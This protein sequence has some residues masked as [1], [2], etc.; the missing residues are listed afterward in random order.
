MCPAETAGLEARGRSEHGGLVKIGPFLALLVLAPALGRADTLRVPEDHKSIQAAIEAARAGDTILVAAGSYREHLVLKPG[1]TVRSAGDD[2]PGELGL[3]RAEATVLD[4]ENRAEAG[5]VMAEGSTLDGFTVTR[6]GRFD[7]ESWNKHYETRGEHQEHEHIGGFGKP[8]IGVD[9]VNCS[10]SNNIVHHNGH[11]GIAVRGTEESLITPIVQRNLC[12][13]NMGGGIGI[14]NKAS[15]V[16]A[17]NTCFRNFYAGIGHSGASPL[18]VSNICYDNIRAG[19]GISE[20]ACPA[21]RSNKCYRNRRAGIGIRTGAHTRPL[22]EDNDCYEN[23]MAGIGTEEE[24]EP[25]ILH[26]RC[27]RNELAGIGARKNARPLLVGNDCRHN[28]AAGIGFDTCE[29][30]EATLIRNEV[31]D[32]A[33][34]AVGIH[35]GWTVHLRENELSRQG[36]LPPIVMVFE[37]AQAT[38]ENNTIRGEGVAGVR[39]AGR[40]T[41]EGN[42]FEGIKMR[43]G[44]P[45]NFGVWALEGSWL[46]MHGN[47]FSSWRHGLLADGAVVDASE[48]SVRGFHRTALVVRNAPRPARLTGNRAFAS[49]KDDRVLELKGESGEVRGN[50]LLPAK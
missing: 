23:G 29:K 28:K 40:A 9:G 50:E 3:K 12:Y 1:L 27:H 35:S 11:T 38:L 25:A 15:G 46:R 42:R 44:G 36:G 37:G 19:I 8:G 31:V 22:V 21:V 2:T 32:N 30:G 49:G 10:I 4:G 48:N 16:I 7:E 6:F 34:V 33:L 39:L 20:G 47:Q 43:P 18:V 13:R 14:M 17:R 5:V 41:L 24:A 45:P 26:N